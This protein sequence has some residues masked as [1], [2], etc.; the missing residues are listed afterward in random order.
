MIPN[1]EPDLQSIAPVPKDTAIA[2]VDALAIVATAP[3]VPAGVAVVAPALAAIRK[4][5]WIYKKNDR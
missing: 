1:M 5:E 4:P 3:K 2:K